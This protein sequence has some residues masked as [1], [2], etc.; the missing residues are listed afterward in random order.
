[1]D[2]TGILSNDRESKIFHQVMA[3]HGA[4][5][6]VRRA[7]NVQ[8]AWDGLLER[9]RRQ[10][11]EWLEMTRV[12]L[13]LLRALAG[14]W[15]ALEPLLADAADVEVLAALERELQPAL[16]QPMAATASQ[17]KLLA[18]LEE[19]IDSLEHFNDRWRNYLAALDLAEVNRLR[20]DYNRYYVFEKECVVRSAAIARQGF[21]RLPPLTVADVAAVFPCLSC[22]RLNDMT[23]SG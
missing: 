10:R 4:P 23:K 16:R 19:F 12:R 6:F 21:Q 3:L 13:A 22:M 7:Q 11:R 15:A 1:M 20:E 14:S 17:R 2:E 9:C 5:A 18:A 8:Y